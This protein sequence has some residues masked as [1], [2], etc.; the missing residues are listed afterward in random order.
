MARAVP[1][2]VNKKNMSNSERAAREKAEAR[3][4]TGTKNIKPPRWLSKDTKKEFR[5]LTKGLL[6][7][8]LVD[9]LDVDLLAVLATAIVAYRDVTSILEKDGRFTEYTNK[10]GATNLMNHPAV[11]QQKQLADQI[12]MLANEFGLTPSARAKL[13]IPRE[14]EPEQTEFDKLFGN[15]VPM[16]RDAR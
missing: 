13:A 15:V 4:R 7:I 1:I 3:L 10:A 5:R 16:R 8:D 11:A 9:N 12:R 14:K 6:E 2:G